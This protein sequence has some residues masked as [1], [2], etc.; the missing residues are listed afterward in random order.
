VGQVGH[1]AS[2]E[3]ASAAHLA[4]ELALDLLGANEAMM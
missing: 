2:S 1:S 3:E 4:P